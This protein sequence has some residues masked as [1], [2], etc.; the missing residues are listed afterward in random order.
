[1]AVS[2]AVPVTRPWMRTS[3]TSFALAIATIGTDPGDS[4]LS[5]WPPNVAGDNQGCAGMAR[6]ARTGMTVVSVFELDGVNGGIFYNE[7]KG[8]HGEQWAEAVDDWYYDKYKRGYTAL[9]GSDT[10]KNVVGLPMY[11]FLCGTRLWRA[12]AGGCTTCRRRC[13]S[14]LRGRNDDP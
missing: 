8:Q 1:G 4:R 13:T 11:P 6:A 10:A 12:M 5:R 14:A 2:V 9:G 7:W 3:T